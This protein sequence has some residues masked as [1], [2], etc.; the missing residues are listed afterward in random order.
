M[1]AFGITITYSIFV[2]HWVED[3]LF[4]FIKREFGENPKLSRSCKF[5]LKTVSD[6][7]LFAQHTGRPDS[8]KR[9]RKPAHCVMI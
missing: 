1:S 5:H 2:A 3:D 6:T 8:G 7:P 4:I 9:V